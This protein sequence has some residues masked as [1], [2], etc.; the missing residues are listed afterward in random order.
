[1]TLLRT[2][3]K[4]LFAAADLLIPTPSGPRIL[5]YHQIGADLGRQ[6]EVKVDDF[7]QQ[8]DWLAENR[9]VID[10]ASA[11]GRW[12]E[13]NSDR[14][15]V[16]T[17]DDGY[18]DTFTTAFPRLSDFGMP[19]TIFLATHSIETGKSLGPASGAEP[20]SWSEVEKMLESGLV[21]VG[22]HTHTHRDLRH[23][24][25]SDVE[26]EISL[27]NDIITDRLGIVPLHFAYPWGYW[28]EVADP[29]V[30]EIYETAVLGGSP[31]PHPAPLAHRLHRYPIQL[32][33]GVAFF[34]PR[35][36]GG[37]LLEESVR[38]RIR[39]YDGP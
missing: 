35:L 7:D 4:A 32:G 18:R 19:F 21:T 5:V 29:V 2:A 24:T 30:K 36:S 8:L 23:V 27:S 20:L 25:P 33:D 34:K 1:M 6:M 10:L 38:R 12:E 11:V 15:V 3:A 37:L 17:F 26:R 9:E 16:L 13:L 39:G 22:A 28:S 14:L 31:H